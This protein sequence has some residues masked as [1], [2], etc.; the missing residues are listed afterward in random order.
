M[1]TVIGISSIRPCATRTASRNPVFARASLRRSRSAA[2]RE[3]SKDRPASP[4]S[5]SPPRHHRRRA[6][7]DARRPRCACGDRSRARRTG[8]LPSPCER[9][10]PRLRALDPEIVG[11]LLLLPEAGDAARDLRAD[12][13]GDPVHGPSPL[14]WRCARPQIGHPRAMQQ[15]RR[16]RYPSRMPVRTAS[17]RADPTTAPSAIAAIARACAGVLMPKPTQMGRSVRTFSAA[18]RAADLG[19]IGGARPRHAGDRDVVDEAR[20]VGENGRHAGLIRRRR[21]EADEVEARVLARAGTAR[22]LPRAAGRRR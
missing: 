19:G 17:T 15:P 13:V 2:R 16:D 4:E 22:R 21:G 10:S 11:R 12:D 3:T 7:S 8:W 18:T 9:P 14:A 1:P 6:P 20:R 5:R